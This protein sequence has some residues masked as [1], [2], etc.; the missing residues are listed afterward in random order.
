MSPLLFISW[1]HVDIMWTLGLTLADLM[2]S[3]EW[4]SLML[5][6]SAVSREV[7]CVVGVAVAIVMPW[8]WQPHLKEIT[9]KTLMFNSSQPFS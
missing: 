6:Q 2:G 8:T 5:F 9:L 7:S 1:M 3:L 4:K